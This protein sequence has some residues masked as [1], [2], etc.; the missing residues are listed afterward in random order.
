MWIPYESFY[1]ASGPNISSA[2]SAAALANLSTNYGGPRL[3]ETDTVQNFPFGTL[4]RAY[5]PILGFGEFIY[6]A[7]VAATVAGSLVNYN[8]VTGATTIN[9]GTAITGLPLAVALAPTVA[10]LFGWYQ[11]SGAANVVVTGSGAVGKVYQVAA[12]GIGVT[13]S[14]TAGMQIIG[15]SQISVASG[16]TFTKTGTTRNGSTEVFV[17]NLD[18]VFVGLPVSGTGIAGGSVVAAG[19]NNSPN[20]RNSSAG[21][22]TSFVMNNAATADGTVTVT[23]TRTGFCVMSG[24]RYFAQGAIT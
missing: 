18:A 3:M 20:A 15:G 21:S 13:S 11:V 8:P 6:L 23:F 4:V 2:S 9:L 1:V 14:A 19:V 22:A 17:S 10:N 5:D 12:S 24:Q 7:G 16:T